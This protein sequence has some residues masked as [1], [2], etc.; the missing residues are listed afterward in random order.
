MHCDMLI[1]LLF[2]VVEMA[3][4]QQTSFSG[5]IG[6]A[7]GAVTVL[8]STLI[9]QNCSFSDNA[10]PATEL[11]VLSGGAI[12]VVGENATASISDTLFTDN[13]AN[14]GGALSLLQAASVQLTDSVFDSNTATVQAGSVSVDAYSTLKAN[15]CK[16]INSSADSGGSVSLGGGVTSSFTNCTF[17]NSSATAE[18]AGAVGIVNAASST[19]TQVTTILGITYL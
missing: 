16:F 15:N 17:D 11:N 2:T 5:N 6:A 12:T 14:V 19:F 13:F 7:S 8:N 10:I 1:L 4:A 18:S 9:A 3:H